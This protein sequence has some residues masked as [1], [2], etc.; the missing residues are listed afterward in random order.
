VKAFGC[1]G[2]KKVSFFLLLLRNFLLVTCDRNKKFQRLGEAEDLWVVRSNFIYVSFQFRRAGIISLCW[3]FGILIGF[4]PLFGWYNRE[5]N[6]EYCYFTEK[7]DYNFLVFL[8]FTTIIAPSVVLAVFYGLI[9]RVIL[10]Q[11]S[12][13]APLVADCFNDS[14]LGLPLQV[15]KTSSSSMRVTAGGSSVN[16]SSHSHVSNEVQMLR[17]LNSAA[18]KREVKATQNLSI[19]VC[20]FMICW[21]P[22]YTINCINAFCSECFIHESFTFFSIILSHVNSAINPLL[23]AY[24]LKDF[25][26]ALIRLFKCT[27]QQ[28]SYYRPSLISQQQQRIASQNN[29]HQLRSFQPRVYVD[30]PI[31]KRQQQQ[32]LPPIPESRKS[33]SDSGIAVAAAPTESIINNNSGSSD[34][35]QPS[36]TSSIT[37]RHQSS[38]KVFIISGTE[39]GCLDE[40]PS[41]P[42][43]SA[44]YRIAAASRQNSQGLD[45]S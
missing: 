44:L 38:H 29:Q 1:S 26:G 42:Q 2:T 16:G 32:Q 10:K 3:M 33:T 12:L 41:S 13:I 7:M 6:E 40:S 27:S 35:W 17:L 23:Y 15:N 39:A 36:P 31:W 25:R 21:I 43:S 28:D 34:D 5:S 45:A 22:L 8:Y 4:L 19:I 11:V 18:Q 30:S 9:Y 20:F 14:I 37:R 24:H